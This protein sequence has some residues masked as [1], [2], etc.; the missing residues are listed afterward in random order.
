MCVLCGAS[1]AVVGICASFVETYMQFLALRFIIAFLCAG[2]M[3]ISFVLG[4]LR[5]AGGDTIR[6]CGDLGGGEEEN[7][8]RRIV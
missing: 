8:T 5:A 1:V 2:L 7:T 6:K 3:V 4:R